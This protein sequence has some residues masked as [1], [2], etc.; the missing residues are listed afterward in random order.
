M[1]ILL[2]KSFDMIDDIQVVSYDNEIININKNSCETTL[3]LMYKQRMINNVLF[4]IIG[5]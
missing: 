4:K 2:Q 3:L 5:N 1:K